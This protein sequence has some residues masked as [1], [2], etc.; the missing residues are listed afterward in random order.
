V[1]EQEPS[2]RNR[3]L[4]LLPYYAG[5]RIGEVVGLD[6]GDVAL[7]GRKGELRVMGKA[8]DGGKLRTVPIHAELRPV[9]RAWLIERQGWPGAQATPALL[10]NARGG[11]I[12]DRYGREII[13]G[14]G[15]LAGLDVDHPETFGPH[16]LRHTFG[17]QLV[18]AGVDLVTVAE[19]MGHARLDATR[20]YTLPAKTDPERALD[21][22]LTDH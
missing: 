12:S 15:R 3:V 4:A 18:R 8:R 14:L 21:A 11:R 6:V 5:L 20:I 2:L 13:E 17:T 19:L 7:S 10:L 16:V 1:V 22:L 9:L